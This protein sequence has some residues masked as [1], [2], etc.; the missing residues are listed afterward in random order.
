MLAAS[1]PLAAAPHQL[2]RAAALLCARIPRARTNTS[3]PSNRF[4]PRV[5]SAE[6][7][8]IAEDKMPAAPGIKKAFHIAPPSGWINDPN[9]PFRDPRT[10]LH[11]L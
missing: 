8:A 10:G 2:P 7:G 11:H 5:A 6:P 3:S 4:A 9:G 1:A